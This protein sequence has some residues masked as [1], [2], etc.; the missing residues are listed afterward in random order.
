MNNSK[1]GRKPL[2]ESV[3]KEEI[4][5]IKVLQSKGYTQ[6]QIAEEMSISIDTVKRRLRQNKE[7][8][9]DDRTK[10]NTIPTSWTKPYLSRHL[11]SFTGDGINRIIFL[12]DQAKKRDL[13]HLE[14]FIKNMI[15]SSIRND[16]LPPNKRM[17]NDAW[18]HFMDGLPVFANWINKKDVVSASNVLI[19]KIQHYKPYMIGLGVQVDNPLNEPKKIKRFFKLYSAIY[20]SLLDTSSDEYKDEKARSDQ[21]KTDYLNDKEVKHASSVI[22]R[23]IDD[24][25]F[26]LSLTLSFDPKSPEYSLQEL[27]EFIPVPYLMEK[28]IKRMTKDIKKIKSDDYM[29][30]EVFVSIFRHPQRG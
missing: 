15:E 17:R 21:A 22:E 9:Q 12:I 30:W 27:K 13:L 20:K 3:K 25:L 1:K 8:S 14:W 6:Q 4:H 24:Y 26:N 19:S 11:E 2:S 16:K 18:L 5:Q 23:E 10:E 29:L 28:E 7:Y